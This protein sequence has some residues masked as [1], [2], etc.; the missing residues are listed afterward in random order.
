VGG[1]SGCTVEAME[2]FAVLRACELAGI[3]AV[4]RRVT[5]IEIDPHYRARW[6]LDDG[7]ALLERTLPRLVETLDA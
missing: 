3:P 2:G 6:R 5:A 7:I 4:E 1:S